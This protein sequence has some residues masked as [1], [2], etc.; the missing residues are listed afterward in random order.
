MKEK[1]F[2]PHLVF[3]LASPFLSLPLVLADIYKKR[4]WAADLFFII[5]A[6]VS[7]FYIPSFTN[8]K[9]RYFEFYRDYQNYNIDFLYNNF[10]RGQPDFLFYLI[11]Y[12]ASK[13]NLSI[14][15]VFAF[16]TYIT[17]RNI[18]V[19]IRKTL[20][21]FSSN[22]YFFAFILLFVAIDPQTLLSGVR[23]IFALSFV[24]LAFYYGIVSRRKLA[25][26]WILL[27]GSIHFSVMLFLI[28]YFVLYF[29][30]LSHRTTVL[31]LI[32]SVLFAFLPHNFITNLTSSLGLGD[33]YAAKVDL[34]LENED[35]LET[36]ATE[37]GGGRLLL[38]LSYLWFYCMYIYIFFTF[39]TKNVWRNIIYTVLPIINV[40][41]VVTTVHSRYSQA[42]KLFFAYLLINEF[43]KSKNKKGF[44]LFFT[45][46]I[47]F[48]FIKLYI[49]RNNLSES[50]FNFDSISL[51]TLI[52]KE[53]IKF[54]LNE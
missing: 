29:F 45:L 39:K 43:G 50:I 53:P 11:F 4:K 28:P 13:I 49:I 38:T 6:L 23:F 44:Y 36:G 35:F 47:I 10:L 33:N 19:P 42:V 51:L 1:S 41:F 12:F 2:F 15:I 46:F 31:L 8:D 3:F 30:N 32:L 22:F 18:Y 9:A 48:F 52:A 40:F 54:F 26:L 34:Y 16:I 5:I 24:V 17:L 37:S 21:S 27:G 20:Y 25:F 14:Q 7:A